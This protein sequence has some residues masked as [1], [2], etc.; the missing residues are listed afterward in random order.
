MSLPFPTK[1]DDGVESENDCIFS[2]VSTVLSV[3]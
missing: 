2:L 3:L 1:L